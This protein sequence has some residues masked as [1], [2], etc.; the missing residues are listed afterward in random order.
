MKGK[1]F[2]YHLSNCEFII[3][4]KALFLSLI[5]INQKFQSP[6]IPHMNETKYKKNVNYLSFVTNQ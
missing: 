3:T 2:L 5:F 6:N 1:K 4:R